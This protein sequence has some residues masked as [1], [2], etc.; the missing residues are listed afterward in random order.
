MKETI[1]INGDVVTVDDNNP[2]AEA[3][4][5]RN[6]KIIYVGD[7]SGAMAFKNDKT[8]VVDLGGKTLLPGFVDGHSHYFMA[9]NTVN[10]ASVAAPPVG[11]VETIDDIISVLKVDIEAGD[12]KT[13]DIVVGWG[14]DESLLK[15]GRVPTNKELD[16]VSTEHPIYIAHASGHKGVANSAFLKKFDINEDSVDPEGGHI[17]RYPGTKTPNGTLEEQAMMPIMMKLFSSPDQSRLVNNLKA[18]DKLYAGSGITTA[19]DGGW[20]PPS[21]QLARMADEQGLLK[22]DVVGYPFVES[23]DTFGLI[24]ENEI[25]SYKGHIKMGGA[26]LILDGSPQAKTAWL[27][28]PYHVAPPGEDETYRGYPFHE[29]DQDVVEVVEECLKRNIQLLTHTNGDQASEQLIACYEKAQKNT[30]I[31]DD[32]RP[33]MI[34]AQTVRDDQLDRMA[35]LKMIPSF[36]QCHTFFWGDWHLDSVLGPERGARISPVCSAIERGITYTLHQDTPVIPPNMI[37]TLWT[38]VNRKTR[39]GRT[40]GEEQKIT[41]M[42]AI[43]G[44]TINGAYQYFEEDT[45]GTITVG[46]RADMVVLD[47]NPVKVA[48]DDIKDIKVL[49]TIKDGEIIFKA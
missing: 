16:K 23:K 39:S 46:K 3:I 4:V 35:Q 30:G 25:G 18:V 22:I 34:H 17:G 38:A 24:D 27:S 15:E 45:K 10:F 2:E 19:Q 40:I 12:Y 20:M 32:F 47:K 42:E 49:E 44:I 8:E 13:G 31:T 43:K 41:V 14:Y 9:A 29:N 37:F 21:L 1:Y 6:G 26:K 7:N 33:V 5:V 36:F 48:P 28:K 11:T